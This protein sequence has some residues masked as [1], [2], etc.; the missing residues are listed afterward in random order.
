MRHPAHLDD[1]RR[2]ALAAEWR[3]ASSTRDLAQP[4]LVVATDSGY[5]A[6]IAQFAL[7]GQLLAV[8]STSHDGVLV[9]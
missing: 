3:P 2:E 8:R 5:V 9:A 4:I 6:E 1:Q 7:A